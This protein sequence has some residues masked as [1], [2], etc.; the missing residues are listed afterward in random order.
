MKKKENKLSWFQICGAGQRGLL[1]TAILLKSNNFDATCCELRCSHGIYEWLHPLQFSLYSHWAQIQ[2]QLA[3]CIVWGSLGVSWD[4]MSLFDVTSDTL[5]IH[6]A[7]VFS[8]PSLQTLN[9]LGSVSYPC[10]NMSRN[11]P[12]LAKQ[13]KT[14]VKLLHTPAYFTSL[15]SVSIQGKISSVLKEAQVEILP[16]SLCNSSEG[17]AGLMDSKA[18]CAGAWAGGTDTCQVRG[19]VMPHLPRGNS[20][21]RGSAASWFVA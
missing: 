19:E 11:T 20:Q 12:R 13:K 17:Y 21:A 6:K 8:N 4:C 1:E 3:S 10:L 5:R 14:T 15:N 9:P 18:L 16:S 7:G 2:C